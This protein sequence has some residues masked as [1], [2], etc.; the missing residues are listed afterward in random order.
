LSLYNQIYYLTQVLLTRQ[1][2]NTND[3]YSKLSCRT[4]NILNDDL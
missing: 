4:I 3:P 2:K 1:N